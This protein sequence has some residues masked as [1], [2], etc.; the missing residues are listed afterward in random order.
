MGGK[1]E[2]REVDSVFSVGRTGELQNDFQ[3]NLERR[4]SL[5]FRKDVHAK[6]TQLFFSLIKQMDCSKLSFIPR[7]YQKYSRTFS[8]KVSSVVQI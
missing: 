8:P 6:K 1:G 7:Q 4:P 3:R 2:V 5:R